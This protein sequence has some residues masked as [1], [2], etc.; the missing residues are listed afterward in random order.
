MSSGSTVSP[1][2]IRPRLISVQEVLV[3]SRDLFPTFVRDFIRLAS[4]ARLRVALQSK[5]FDW[6]DVEAIIR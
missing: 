3:R 6:T 2:A 4:A 1:S 5:I